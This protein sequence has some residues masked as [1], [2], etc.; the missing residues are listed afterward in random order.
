MVVGVDAGVRAGVDIGV[1]AGE[2]LS[3]WSPLN[4]ALVDCPKSGNPLDNV[5]IRGSSATFE[6]CDGSG[7]LLLVP[8]HRRTTEALTRS[9]LR[10][11]FNALGDPVR[12]HLVIQEQRL[13]HPL[14]LNEKLVLSVKP[15]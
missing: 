15:F 1:R 2:Q 4:G 6:G 14:T 5:R 12:V 8:D 7:S 11:G 3:A 9:F 10:L 13:R